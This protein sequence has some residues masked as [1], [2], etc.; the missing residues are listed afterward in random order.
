MIFRGRKGFLSVLRYGLIAISYRVTVLKVQYCDLTQGVTVRGVSVHFVVLRC[1]LVINEKL[2][3]T[4][5]IQYEAL[6]FKMTLNIK[7]Y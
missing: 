1:N 7:K 2:F 5:N 6:F 4:D 3:A